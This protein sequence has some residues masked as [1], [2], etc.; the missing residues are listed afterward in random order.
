MALFGKNKDKNR[1][2]NEGVPK[3]ISK[4]AQFSENG[5]HKFPEFEI[6]LPEETADTASAA[7]PKT[8]SGLD[9]GRYFLPDRRVMLE[10]ISYE[11]EQPKL[12]NG[13]QIRLEGRDTV[14]AQVML[15]RGVKVTFN[16]AL[17]FEPDGPFTLSVSFA[18]MLIFNPATAGEVDWKTVDVATEFK[19]SCP[20]LIQNMASR[21]ALLVAEIT[22]AAG[23]MPIIKA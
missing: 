18:V 7:V 13:T 2:E 22:S 9:F 5:G 12:A 15:P 14:V 21:A 6:K 16:R 8:A 1:E 10:N 11:T 19:R 3:D 4:N 23:A 20:E 17:R